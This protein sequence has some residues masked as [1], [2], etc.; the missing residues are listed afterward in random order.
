MAAIAAKDGLLSL[1]EPAA[2]TL[3]EWQDDPQREKITLRHLLSMTSGHKSR[4]GRPPGYGKAVASDIA[5]PPGSKFLYG[6]VPSQIFG[7]V[8]RLKLQAY[9]KSGGPKEYLEEHLF[10][11]LGIEDY[12]WRNGPDKQPLMPQGVVMSARDWAKFGEFVRSGGQIG[13]TQIVDP[14]TFEAL[15]E[16]GAANAAYGLSWWLPRPSQSKDAVTATTDI[17]DYADLLPADMVVAAGAGNQ[18]LYVIPSLG[19]TIVR[20]AEL[21]LAAALRGDHGKWS[22]YE[23]IQLALEAVDAK[24]PLPSN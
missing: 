11:P 7:E 10:A 13:G 15:F 16:G 12:S 17:D 8:M 6:P 14:D 24:A 20:L 2:A 18:R 22:D 5:A 3:T 21:D 9:G 23:F 1:D 4:V 19:V